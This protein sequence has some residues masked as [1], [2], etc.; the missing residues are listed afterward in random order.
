MP[1]HT[2][3]NERPESQERALK[4][5]EKLG[6]ER[7][8][9]SDSDKKRNV[10]QSKKNV[11]YY[12]ELEKFLLK[13]TYDYGKG[14][15]R[16]SSASITNAINALEPI[17]PNLA[18]KN[19]S[20]YETLCKGKSLEE[21]LPN[22]VQSFDINYI[23]FDNIENNTFQVTDE[24]SVERTAG[25]TNARPD[26]VILINGIPLVVIECKK[27][28][29]DVIEGVRQNIRNQKTDYIPHLFQYS[30]L[31]IAMNPDK[32]LYGT[33]GT[34][35]EHFTFWHEDN[36]DRLL[37]KCKECSPDGTVKE[38]DK[39]I[40]SLLEPKRLLDLIENF[41]IYDNKIKKIARYK[42]Y[43]AVKKSMARILGQDGKETHNGVIWHTQGSGKTLTMI[44]LAKMIL[45]ESYKPTSP[46]KNPR[47]VMVTDRINLDKQISDNFRKTSMTPIK[48]TSGKNLVTLLQNDNNTVITS[49]VNKFEAAI[50]QR[51]KKEDDNI[52]VFIDEGHRTQYG[53]LNFYM[54]NV[55]PNAVKIAFTGTPLISKPK[56]NSILPARDTFK[57]FGPLIDSYTFTDAINDGVTVPIVYEGRI[58]PQNVTNDEINKHLQM[59]TIG[60][61]DE[62]KKDLEK[63]YSQYIRLSQ[64][65]QRLRIL[66]FD[67]Y[68]H[69][70]KYVKSFNYKA[71]LTCSS[72][73]SAVKM[74]NL[75]KTFQNINPA[76]VISGSSLK[77]GDDEVLTKEDEILINNFFKDVVDPQYKNNYDD[78]EDMVTENFVD[79]E[80]DIDFLIVKDKLLTGFDAPVAQVLYVDKSLKE[81]NLLQAI[82]R[83]NRVFPEKAFGL[84][85]DYCGIFKKLNTAMDMYSDE[86]S[87]L[88]IFSEKDLEGALVSIADQKKQIEELYSKLFSFFEGIDK[89]ESNPNKWQTALEDDQKRKEFY[90]ISSK[91]NK[92][93]DLLF[94]SIDLYNEIGEN[95]AKIYQSDNI[96][97]EKL[98]RSVKLR[99]NDIVDFSKYE[100]GVKALIDTHVMAETAKT[101]IAPLDISCKEKMEEQLEILGDNS[102]AKADAI[103]TRQTEILESCQY[104]DP[105][106]Y[107]TFKD[108]INNTLQEYAK[109][110][111][112]EKYLI[113]ME[114]I[115]EDFQLGLSQGSYPDNITFDSNA[116]SFFGSMC[117]GLK[118]KNKS[119]KGFDNQITGNMAI[120]IKKVIEDNTTKPDWRE[121]SETIKNIKAKLDNIL[122][123]YMDNN[124]EAGWDYDLVD[125]IIE[126]ILM[127]AKR[128]Y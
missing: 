48:A 7:V 23:D 39:S 31:V 14:P 80:G 64:T 112:A 106:K 107:I 98:K 124:K 85:V 27:S 15:T 110:R 52:F 84:V 33:C 28:A 19:K 24:F 55:L 81:H 82:A 96:F 79:P 68:D 36:T 125:I 11:L 105:L 30:Q 26:I 37:E 74:Y 90:D 54:Q 104:D 35:E 127:T 40:I 115:R 128:I 46:F 1:N 126:E 116:K 122:C 10:S 29:V 88:D 65:D 121:S 70:I 12:D 62:A 109:E 3:L 66:A 6:Y 61:N 69:F 75:L 43:F 108:R 32:V 57:K 71:M 117:S 18:A 83:V 51:F 8:S 60:L 21:I 76:V 50:K 86:K 118:K 13:Q 97:F 114:N 5:L 119:S 91:F 120:N 72:R 2:I 56:R 89:N 111:D 47:F 17:E 103:R 92:Y 25:N 58:I 93:I 99:Y 4:V 100:S 9:V 94:S 78:Y 67:I 73:A 42:Q 34:P 38:Q 49:I 53:K 77:E 45:K 22:G 102:A 63:K 113:E 16:F 101:L 87:E 44:M 59:I 20:I 95:Q 123:D 41:I